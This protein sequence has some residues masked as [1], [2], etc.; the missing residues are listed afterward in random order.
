MVVAQGAPAMG[1]FALEAV[2]TTVLESP[3]TAAALAAASPSA[4]ERL[5]GEKLFPAIARLQPGLAS[6]IT[7]MLLDM[8]N[9]ELLILL[10]F[11]RQLQ[12]MAEEALR[13]LAGARL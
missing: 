8:G 11:D 9:S 3:L 12:T 5:I 13:A 7:G 6:K 4:Q 1:V 2:A 10:G